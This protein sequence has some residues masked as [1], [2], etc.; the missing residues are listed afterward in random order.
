MHPEISD[1]P[2][3]DIHLPDMVLW[4]PLAPGWWLL[5]I[6]GVLCLIAVLWYRRHFKFRALQKAASKELDLVFTAY[7]HHY[8]ARRFV[9]ELSVLLR[10]I[11]ITRYGAND[12]AHLT[13][14]KWLQFLVRG[15]RP[16][17]NRSGLKFTTG[18]G[19]NLITVP[20]RS[21]KSSSNSSSNSS[22]A[23]VQVDVEALHQLAVEW[24]ASLA[25]LNELDKNPSEAHAADTSRKEEA[26]VSV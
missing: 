15:L 16:S 3:R 11:S 21:F 10:R 25:T 14:E 19:R 26:Y 5:L 7:R 20:Y 1:V 22:S 24:I 17:L 12:I 8:D 13:G 2:I 9:Q 6:L 4:W 23:R 18:E